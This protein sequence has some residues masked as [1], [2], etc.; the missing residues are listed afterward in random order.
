MTKKSWQQIANNFKIATSNIFW[1]I[2]NLGNVPRVI[3]LI[4]SLI[5]R[6]NH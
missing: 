2:S 6:S 3:Q 5:I 1:Y 4:T